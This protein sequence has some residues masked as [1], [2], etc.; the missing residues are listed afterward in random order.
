ME[1]NVINVSIEDNFIV[2]CKI[3]KISLA[4]IGNR[5]LYTYTLRIILT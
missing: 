1:D 5:D 3:L 4:L 2:Q